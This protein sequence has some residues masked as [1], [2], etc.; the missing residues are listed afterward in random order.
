MVTIQTVRISID[1]DSLGESMVDHIDAT[2]DSIDLVGIV[3]S[4]VAAALGDAYNADHI[5]IDCD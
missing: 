1:E 2:I 5:D 4:A 3:Q